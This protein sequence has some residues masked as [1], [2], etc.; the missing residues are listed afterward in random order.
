MDSRRVRPR[1]GEQG[2]PRLQPGPPPMMASV[3]GCEL[4]AWVALVWP[5]VR[6][7]GGGDAWPRPSRGLACSLSLAFPGEV[8]P[9]AEVYALR[10]G[11][12]SSGSLGMGGSRVLAC[13]PMGSCCVRSARVC[14]RAVGHVCSR[15][16]TSLP[17]SSPDL[18]R[19]GTGAAHGGL[20]Q[21]SAAR[22]RAR[23]LS[24][25]ASLVCGLGRLRSL[26]SSPSARP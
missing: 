3:E 26:A 22:S 25:Y 24:L 7:Q 8:L 12:L 16:V 1:A 17:G 18:L 2:V 4:R 9:Q 21:W 14:R 5:C 23:G 10:S 19:S 11:C 13:T 15:L 6:P 20:G